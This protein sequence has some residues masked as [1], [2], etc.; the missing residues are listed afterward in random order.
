M[1]VSNYPAELLLLQKYERR[2]SLDRSEKFSSQELLVMNLSRLL[3]MNLLISPRVILEMRIM[4]VLFE[5]EGESLQITIEVGTEMVGVNFKII[6][7][8]VK[9]IGDGENLKGNWENC[10]NILRRENGNR[11]SFS[12]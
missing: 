8:I 9:N 12:K 3:V 10:V 1:H 2:Y 11:Q 6:V 5:V 7:F 4:K